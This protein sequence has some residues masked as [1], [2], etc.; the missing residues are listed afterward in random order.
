M[1]YDLDER[2]IK[3]AANVITINQKVAFSFSTKN[4]QE[5]LLRSATSIGANYQEANGAA[6]KS[7]FRNKISICKKE[8]LETQ[9]WIRLMATLDTNNK[10]AWNT[11]YKECHELLLIFSRIFHS[12]R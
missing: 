6:S 3:F 5:Q 2:T 1:K 11:L 10:D 4:I 7:D 12:S 9:Y 8:A